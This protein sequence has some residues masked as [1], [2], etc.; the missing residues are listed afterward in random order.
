MTNDRL[1]VHGGY[2]INIGIMNDFHY[3]QIEDDF[4][5]NNW[6]IVEVKSNQNPGKT[7]LLHKVIIACFR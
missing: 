4:E 5:I 3:I 1:Y 7:L 2:D 6:E